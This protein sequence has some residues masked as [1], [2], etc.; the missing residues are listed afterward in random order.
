MALREGG[1]ARKIEKEKGREGWEER[2]KNGNGKR[3]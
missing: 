3:T 1:K 2:M